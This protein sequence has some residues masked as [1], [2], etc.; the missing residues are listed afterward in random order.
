MSQQK[1]YMSIALF[2]FACIFAYLSYM[3]YNLKAGDDYFENRQY[4]MMGTG[5]LSIGL[6]VAAL[7]YSNA[8][9]FILDLSAAG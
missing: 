9:K 7:Y 5:M 6:L 1:I 4:L 3:A 8:G 2:V